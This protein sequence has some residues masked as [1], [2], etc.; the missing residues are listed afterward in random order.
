MKTE[1]SPDIKWPSMTIERLQ[2]VEKVIDRHKYHP[3]LTNLGLQVS[4]S[5]A[6]LE[7]VDGRH[8]KRTRKFLA[9]LNLSIL[10]FLAETMIADPFKPEMID[11]A[12]KE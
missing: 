2:D 3:V 5:I 4:Q 12:V 6:L 11:E 10:K 1:P 9:Q 7:N 8:N